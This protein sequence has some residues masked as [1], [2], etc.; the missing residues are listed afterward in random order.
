MK[1]LV[2]EDEDDI[3]NLITVQLTAEGHDVIAVSI[4]MDAFCSVKKDCIDM[5]ILDIIMS[6]RFR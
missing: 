4:G 1:I 2:A 5:A 6:C 3:R